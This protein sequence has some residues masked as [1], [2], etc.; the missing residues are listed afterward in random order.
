MHDDIRLWI[1]ETFV[2]ALVHR[3]RGEFG[4]A[5][6]AFNAVRLQAQRVGIRW[7]EALA[8]IELD[9]T[10]HDAPNHTERPLQ[11]AAAIV[12]ENFPHSFLA[13]RI[14]RWSQA[15]V[16]P[17]ASRLAPQPRE[18]L[19]HLLTGKNPKEIAAAMKLSED[20]VKGYTK[21]LFRAFSVNS[22][23]QL[24]VACY[25]R[26]IG[27]PSWWSVLDESGPAAA[28]RIIVGAGPAP[29]RS[30]RSAWRCRDLDEM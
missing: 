2:R 18:V 7:R 26:G 27:S 1:L 16:D 30:A 17:V 28:Q 24:L 20:T 19:K 25:E 3:G 23:P 9:A 21:T 10:P 8:L 6:A 5:N 12:R 13:Q 29:P 11:V 22:T 14:G 4:K 15:L